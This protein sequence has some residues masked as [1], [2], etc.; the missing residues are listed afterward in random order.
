MAGHRAR[1]TVAS[2]GPRSCERGEEIELRIG[3][4]VDVASTGPRSCERGEVFVPKNE[5]KPVNASTGPRSCERGEVVYNLSSATLQLLQRGRARVS[6]E[7]SL[8]PWFTNGNRS[9]QRGRARV[10]AERNG[11]LGV[12][13]NSSELQRGRARVSAER[14]EYQRTLHRHKPASTGPRSC[15]RGE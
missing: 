12:R 2:T 4:R 8:L 1:L 14:L 5:T 10:S 6:A 9:L 11:R 7:S 15:E 13:C 3:A